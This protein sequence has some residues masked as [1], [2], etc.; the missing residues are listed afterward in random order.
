MIQDRAY[1]VKSRD[2]AFEEWEGGTPSTLLVL[3]TGTGKTVVA[4]MIH[5]RA[6][7]V[8]GR[9]GLFLAHREELIIQA[10]EKL[11]DF[12]LSCAVEMGTAHA[13][14][15]EGLLGRADVTIATVQTM[16][17][18]RLETWPPDAFGVITVDEA[19][20]A[21]AA[22]YKKILDY[23]RGY[24]LLGITATPDRGDKKNL[25]VAFKSLAYDY[26]LAEA[27]RDGYLVPIVVARLH[28]DVDLGD[29]STT[30]GD[31]STA[32]LEEAIGPHVESLAR[33]IREEIALRP[34]VVFTPDVG[35]A[36]MMA[37]A[38][39]QLGVTAEAVSGKMPRVD[40]RDALDRFKGGDFQAVCCCELL[41]EGWDEP[42]VSAVVVA[43]PT[44]KR[45]R[46]AQMIGRG[47]R[48]HATSDKSDCLVVDFAWKTTA[49]HALCTSVALFDDGS[50]AP[51]TRREAEAVLAEGEIK[52]PQQAIAEAEERLRRRELMKVRLTGA[53]AKYRKV[54]YDPVGV[55]HLLGLPIKKGWDFHP[56]HPASERQLSFLAR[57]GCDDPAGLSRSGAGK[58]IS[59]LK[60]RMD[61]GL[62]TVKQV[63]LLGDLGVAPERAREMTLPEASA[64]IDGLLKRP[65]TG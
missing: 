41:I 52:D 53:T 51:E 24:W 11:S 1:Q 23:F 14:R 46:Y 57:L 32:E 35:S 61:K 47:T 30:G 4:G 64:A 45:A 49:D 29:I 15:N 7:D 56:S 5:R 2:R 38:L 55:G 10:E 44:R 3:P 36:E 39:V 27:I 50:M 63:A 16:Q 8:H 60:G 13:R 12:D 20:H 17:G 43:R 62:A 37:S 58:L 9:R 33:A 54:V 19:H 21:R 26:P 28:T 18:R 65:R 40:R 6:L 31:F 48:P 34:T 25:G 59:A 22:T 42:Q